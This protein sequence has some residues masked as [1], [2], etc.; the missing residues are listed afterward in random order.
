MY[1]LIL[2]NI[3]EYIRV[4]FGDD[5]WKKIK[6]DLKIEVVSSAKKLCQIIVS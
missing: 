5:K 6:E 2:Q 4:K 3:A 1:G